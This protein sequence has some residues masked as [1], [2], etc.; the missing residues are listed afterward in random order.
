MN[1][2]CGIIYKELLIDLFVRPAIAQ[3]HLSSVFITERMKNRK[4]DY[5]KRK[6]TN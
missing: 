1:V 6:E 4:R 3:T 5:A 2:K